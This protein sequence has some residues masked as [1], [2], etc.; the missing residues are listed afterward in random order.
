MQNA[1][2]SQFL[3]FNQFAKP[4]IYSNL[5]KRLKGACDSNHTLLEE[6]WF[7]TSCCPES[8]PVT[9]THLS[10]EKRLLHTSNKKL[11][12]AT[13][14]REVKP[15]LSSDSVG[16]RDED[17]EKRATRTIHRQ[18]RTL[19]DTSSR[20]SHQ[21]FPLK[22]EASCLSKLSLLFSHSFPEIFFVRQTQA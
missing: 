7:H 9:R 5:L 22:Q 1:K 15:S 10:L 13:H 16:G 11:N 6:I 20:K 17:V 21:K 14:S 12:P 3:F 2:Q 19:T 4:L 18:D 8:S